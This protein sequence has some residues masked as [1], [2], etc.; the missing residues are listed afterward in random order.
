MS[1]SPFAALRLVYQ[2]HLSRFHIY[3]FIY[4]I[5]LSLSDLLLFYYN[6]VSKSSLSELESNTTFVFV[7]EYLQCV[8]MDHNF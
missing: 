5:F 7:A 6:R 1:A 2:Y 4:D 8:Y 3:V